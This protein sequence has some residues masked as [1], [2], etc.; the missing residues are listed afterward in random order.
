MPSYNHILCSQTKLLTYFAKIYEIRIVLIIFGVY[1][2]SLR[3]HKCFEN[4]VSFIFTALFLRS[5]WV[6]VTV[7]G[8][9][10]GRLT[11]HRALGIAT[12]H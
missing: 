10:E 11:Q 9:N 3:N 1:I 12:A 5:R 6:A 4:I 8:F 2:A 7:E